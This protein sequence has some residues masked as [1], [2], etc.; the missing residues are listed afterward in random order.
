[1]RWDMR[2]LGLAQV[3]SSIALDII[4]LCFPLPIVFR[5]LL[6]PRKKLMVFAMFWL[7]AL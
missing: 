3:Y 6:S 4:V 7:G 1:M 2:A 5:M